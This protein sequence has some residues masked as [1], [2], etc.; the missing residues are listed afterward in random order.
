VTAPGDHLRSLLSYYDAE[1]RW[2]AAGG[3]PAG[4]DFSE[5]GA[6]FHPDVV[7]HQG[8]TV[9]YPGDWHG[10]AGLQAL[11]A[12]FSRTWSSLELTGIRCFEGDSGVATTMRMQATSRGSGKRLDTSVAHLY[13]F[14]GALIQELTIYYLDPVSLREA[15]VPVPPRAV[16][17]P[18]R[19]Q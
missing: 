10:I 17:S 3:A 16:D 2:I 14:D 15:T 4:A 13:A 19:A 12:A 1:Q 6:H 9:P 8:P 5:V 7:T 18:T 11:F